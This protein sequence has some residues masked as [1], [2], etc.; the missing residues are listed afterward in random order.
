MDYELR[1]V[2]QVHTNMR[3]QARQGAFI[4][5]KP[6]GL[7]CIKNSLLVLHVAGRSEKKHTH[8]RTC[9]HSSALR[10]LTDGKSEP[11]FICLR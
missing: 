9:I 10:Q 8:T 6:P 1:H 2:D 4:E 5:K 11:R 7:F 3:S